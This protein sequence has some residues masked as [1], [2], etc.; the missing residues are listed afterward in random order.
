[1]PRLVVEGRPEGVGRTDHTGNRGRSS[2]STTVSRSGFESDRAPQK[3]SGGVPAGFLTIPKRT[4]IAAFEPDYRRGNEWRARQ[5]ALNR[6][7]R[8]QIGPATA[9][10]PL[11][12]GT[13]RGLGSGEVHTPAQLP[14]PYPKALAA[15]V[16]EGN[17]RTGVEI[18]PFEPFPADRARYFLTLVEQRRALPD[19]HTLWTV[20]KAVWKALGG[21]GESVPFTSLELDFDDAGMLR[22]GV[23]AGSYFTAGGVVMNPWPGY[24]LAMAWIEG[25]DR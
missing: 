17:L 11:V 9:L 8:D 23:L 7:R 4:Q 19:R 12:R 24:I 20:K 16:P 13:L 5:L 18:A 15:S 6:I 3:A 2:M 22:G 25:D 14:L 10:P 1:M 21:R